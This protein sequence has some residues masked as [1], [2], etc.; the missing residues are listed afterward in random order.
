[1]INVNQV[2]DVYQITFRYDPSV[3]YLIKQV[4]G[5]RWNPD[6]KY[7]SIPKNNLGFLINQFKGTVYEGSLT[8]RS[9]EEINV[10]SD[11]DSTLEIPDVDISRLKM[12][13]KE[14]STPYQHQKDFMKY[15]IHR[16]SN[17]NMSG[18]ILT[19]E[20]GLGKTL[21]AINLA[22]YNKKKNKFK[23]CLIICCVN[24]SKF[25][26]KNDILDHTNGEYDGYILGT[27]IKRD[28]NERLGGSKEKFEDLSS[29]QMHGAKRGSKL[30]YFI[31][32]NIEALRYK[33]KKSY[34]IT[35]AII[36]LINSGELDMIVIDEIHKNASPSSAQGKQLLKIKK[37]TGSKV[38]WIPMTG[39]PITNRP[40]DVFIP[41]KLVDGHTFNSFYMW[42]QE[43]CVYGG[44]GG[45][46]IIGYKNIQHL[47]AMLQ[48]NMLRRLKDDV[49]D[50]PP[51]VYY[52][53]YVE[54]TPYQSKLY[55]EI[56][57]EVIS[58]RSEILDSLNP[59]ARLLRLRQVN[60][61]PELVDKSIKVD[62]SY[63]KKNAKL[64]RL[65]ELLEDIHDRGEKVV[66]F[67]NW[68]EPLRT[69]YRFVSKKYKTC[70]FTGT[71]SA[72]DREKH[73]RVFQNNPEYTV[74]VGT[75]GA[76]GTT[77]TFTAAS[78][79][80]FY[81]EPWTPSDKMQA[82]D[83][84]HR[85]GTNRSVNIYTIITK[86]TVDERVNDI[87]YTKR[88]ISKYI[89][90]NQLDLRKNPKLFDILMKDTKM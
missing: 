62:S 11:I 26:W 31:I 1:M 77:H 50:L 82:E 43:F 28:G 52:T 22:L 70:A 47:K 63:I 79:V 89:V 7:W 16:Q 56:A 72:E 6:G 81:D 30:P 24:S 9:D 45:H 12:Y 3:V 76:A 80:I 21:E 13:V 66:I 19:D 84:C 15:S 65:M 38:E 44:Y 87:L 25:N 73:K 83:R 75:I 18:F 36:D 42:C 60:G 41:L 59:V 69:L 74:L 23:R 57:R 29:K 86:D 46:E 64:I 27:R 5:R 14:G 88:S 68:V 34:K 39:T 71:M 8:I 20:Q 40:T 78:N 4:P 67:S 54:N 49:L 55:K 35:E 61:S 53:E 85:I 51:K 48:G 33:E 90:D 32:L 10:N 37:A 58:T 2:D 17:G